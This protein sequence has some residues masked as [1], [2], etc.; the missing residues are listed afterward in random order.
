MSDI[1]GVVSQ[2]NSELQ[3]NNSQRK[4]TVVRTCSEEHFGRTPP[5]NQAQPQSAAIY[6]ALDPEMA[7]L[8]QFRFKIIIDSP[9]DLPKIDNPASG[10]PDNPFYAG[11]APNY[12]PLQSKDHGGWESVGSF[13]NTMYG[14]GIDMDNSFGYQCWDMADYFY[15]NQVGTSFATGKDA[16]GGEAQMGVCWS[17]KNLLARNLNTVGGTMKAIE[18]NRDIEV[19]DIVIFDATAQSDTGHVGMAL[20]SSKSINYIQK[21]VIS[22]L[23]QNQGGYIP[24]Q[25]GGAFANVCQMGIGNIL[26]VFRYIDEHFDKKA[27]SGYDIRTTPGGGVLT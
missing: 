7:Y 12:G 26:G 17:W 22:L 18:G 19:G 23:G 5:S 13:Y 24:Y 4:H 2:M 15:V 14:H 6:F 21:G 27:P 20:D 11:D 9:F 25:G 3:S 16:G 1:V 10:R 8:S